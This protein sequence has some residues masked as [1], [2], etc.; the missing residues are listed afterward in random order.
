MPPVANSTNST[1][2]R[3][4]PSSE[5]LRESLLVLEPRILFDAAA[6]AT[7][8]EVAT[9]QVAQDQADAAVNPEGSQ[10]A[11]SPEA[12]EQDALLQAIASVEPASNRREMVFVDTGVEDYQTLIAG[13]DPSAEV[14]LLDATR[15]GIEQIA[16][17]LAGRSDIDAIHIVS[18]GDQ[19][20]LQL[21]TGRLT[22]YSMNGEYADEL[23]TIGQALTE[24]GDILIYGCNFGE[25]TLGQD[26]A[27]RLAELTG[28]DIAASDDPT[29]APAPGGTPSASLPREHVYEIWIWWN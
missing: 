24:K 26:A 15:D 16:E 7:G 4:A 11:T 23:A 1:P 20:E 19:A 9:D 13:L 3:R 10:A 21:G 18:H 2:R 29:G 6:V 28:A 25:G 8:A 12:D 5:K 22:L 14:V 17:A 27:A